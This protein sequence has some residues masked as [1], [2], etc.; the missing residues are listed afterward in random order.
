MPYLNHADQ[1]AQMKGRQNIAISHRIFSG[2]RRSPTCS[3]G[4]PAK[5]YFERRGQTVA[6]RTDRRNPESKTYAPNSIA[7]WELR[8]SDFRVYYDVKET[9]ELMVYIRAVGI[10][11]RNQ[12][13]IGKEV[14]EL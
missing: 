3:D 2:S 12:V 4:T 1:D 5:Y 13:Y 9:P 14:I 10:K 11:K 8:I 6:L 7:P